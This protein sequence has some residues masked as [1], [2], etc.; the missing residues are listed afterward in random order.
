M[1]AVLD[2]ADRRFEKP[3]GVQQPQKL[4][5]ERSGLGEPPVQIRTKIVMSIEFIEQLEH[6]PRSPAKVLDLALSD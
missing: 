1:R 6:E 5:I 3:I 2:D 4:G